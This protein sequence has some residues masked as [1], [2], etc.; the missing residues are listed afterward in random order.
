[1]ADRAHARADAE[2]VEP[3]P[4]GPT[5]S[6]WAAVAA[7]VPEWTPEAIAKFRSEP[8]IACACIGP[9]SRE[10]HRC[11]CWIRSEAIRQAEARR[12]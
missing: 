7:E 4:Y 9:I 12:M 10:R 11:G 8:P 2:R 6:D 3:E 5:E 1:M